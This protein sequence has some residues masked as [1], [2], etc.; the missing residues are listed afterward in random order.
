[1]PVL[2]PAQQPREIPEPTGTMIMVPPEEAGWQRTPTPR[3]WKMPGGGFYTFGPSEIEQVPQTQPKIP[4]QLGFLFEMH[5]YKVAYG[6][7]NSLKS[8]SFARAL[9]LIASTQKIRVLCTR[10]VQLTIADSV[11]TVLVIQI[12]AMGLES[13]FAIQDNGIVCRRTG[14]EF[15]YK[16]LSDL[17][18]ESVKSFE[19]FDVVWCEE[20]QKITKRSWQI[21]LPTIF[22]T[23][24]AEVWVTFNPDMDD[25]ETYVRFVVNPPPGAK[26]VEMNYRDAIEKG[27]FTPEQEALR[28]YDLIHSKD[29][30]ENIWEGKVR[31]AVVGAIYA[32]EISDMISERRYTRMPY[33][34]RLPVD[35]VL[36]LGWNDLMAVVMVQKPH[37]SAVAII[38]YFEDHQITYAAM[39]QALKGLG[40]NFGTWWLP[41]D[42]TQHHPT[43]GTNAEK[44]L[45]ALGCKTRII[46]RTGDEPRIRAARM[47]F[48]RVLLD[49][50]KRDVDPTRPMRVI[51]GG[52]LMERL[53]RFRR[54]VPKQTNEPGAPV[55]DINAHGADAF[56]G[57]AE[58]VDQIRNE[59]DNVVETLPE[60][61][62]ADPGVG[63]LG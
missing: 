11:H 60:F 63:L 58:I 51:G 24:N 50:T 35:C 53:K 13:F 46:P 31:T 49:P 22:R 27:W 42:A 25:D 32:R 38:N 61:R 41:H 19:G 18:A 40:Y 17:T 21:L 54:I 36:D 37:P 44:Q 9:V 43:S 39:L 30:Y 7:R 1:L 10:E 57:L 8:W 20:A 12:R 4:K 59:S 45:K 56:G 62:N 28:Q 15:R 23:P 2:N 33:D 29:D 47:M 5:P 6:G 48:P 55:S 16:G 34:P 52:F 14:S 3:M 26:V